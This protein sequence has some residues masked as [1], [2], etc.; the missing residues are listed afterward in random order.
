MAET[1]RNLTAVIQSLAGDWNW[2]FRYST[3]TVHDIYNRNSD[4]QK[5]VGFGNS[6]RTSPSMDLIS[7]DPQCNS[8]MKLVE[9]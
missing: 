5:S 6:G 2:L 7:E 1:K 3:S 9:E 8:F 4:F